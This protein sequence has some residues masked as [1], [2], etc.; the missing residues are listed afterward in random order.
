[1]RVPVCRGGG[2]EVWCSCPE[3]GRGLTSVA[4]DG[5]S[6]AVFGQV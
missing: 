1:M 3:W 2:I 6:V 5:V 4:V